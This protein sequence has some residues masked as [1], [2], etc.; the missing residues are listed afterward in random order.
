MF[1]RDYTTAYRILAILGITNY[2]IMCTIGWIMAGTIISGIV[3]LLIV[4][5]L[6]YQLCI[7]KRLG[8][9]MV[10][11]VPY[12]E[13]RKEFTKTAEL[14]ISDTHLLV[15]VSPR[16]GTTWNRVNIRFVTRK[17]CPSLT[18][19]WIYKDADSDIVSITDF[20]DIIQEGKASSHTEDRYFESDADGVGG[21]D[22]DYLPPL[23][24]HGG[25][26]VWYD[27]YARAN[28]FWKGWLSFEGTIDN[29]RAWSRIKAEVKAARLTT[30][31]G[32]EVILTRKQFH[33]PLDKAPQTVKKSEKEKP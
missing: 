21:Y 23:L 13:S 16:K 30:A 12:E 14:E 1:N 31:D 28:D 32:K 26:L 25:E 3:L 11:L 5:P 22:G 7:K 19:F 18:R 4:I 6:V 10:S 24:V 33:E 15:Y 2:I 8:T 29:H 27:V 17:F 20:R 9:M